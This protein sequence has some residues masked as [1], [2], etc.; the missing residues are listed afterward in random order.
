MATLDSTKVMYE[1][2]VKPETHSFPFDKD[3]DWYISLYIDDAHKCVIYYL[4]Q[5]SDWSQSEAESYLLSM[6]VD[7]EH[8]EGIYNGYS[9]FKITANNPDTQIKTRLS[10]IGITVTVSSYEIGDGST[11]DLSV[12]ILIKEGISE[13]SDVILFDDGTGNVE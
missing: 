2:S 8:R 6:G 7:P 9:L 1:L 13:I 5:N 4:K 11:N 12:T 3:S 10:S